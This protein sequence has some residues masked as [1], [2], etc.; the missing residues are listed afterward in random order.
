MVGTSTTYLG[1]RY[2]CVSWT[3]ALNLI[4]MCMLSWICLYAG[5]HCDSCTTSAV[6][7]CTP[8]HAIIDMMSPEGAQNMPIIC[9]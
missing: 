6:C 7:T 3:H 4:V 1:A 9:T 8:R 2:A 5:V